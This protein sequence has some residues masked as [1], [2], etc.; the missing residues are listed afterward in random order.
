VTSEV[1]A[2]ALSGLARDVRAAVAERAQRLRIDVAGTTTD[3]QVEELVRRHQLSLRT[4]AGVRELL[5]LGRRADAGAP[6]DPAIAAVVAE[7]APDVVA[8]VRSRRRRL[9]DEPSTASVDE[10]LADALGRTPPAVAKP[11]A[12]RR[13]GGEDVFAITVATTLAV[14]VVAALVV[15]VEIAAASSSGAVVMVVAGATLVGAAAWR[16]LTPIEMW[17]RWIGLRSGRTPPRP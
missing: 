17:L 3:E 1:A 8:T 14:L 5:A 12:L 15:G 13:P 16:F 2:A 9:P 6:V 4:A 10:R 11:A 7:F